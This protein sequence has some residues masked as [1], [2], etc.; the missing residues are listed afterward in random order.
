ML[1][2][3]AIYTWITLSVY[4]TIF[5]VVTSFKTTAKLGKVQ[6]PLLLLLEVCSCFTTGEYYEMYNVHRDDMMSPCHLDFF[7]AHDQLYIMMCYSQ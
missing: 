5:S 4:F 7:F 3:A 1:I 2:T 6:D